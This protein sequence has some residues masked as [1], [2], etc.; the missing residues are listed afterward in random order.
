MDATPLPYDLGT[1]VVPKAYL[2]TRAD[3]PVHSWKFAKVCYVYS[4]SGPS[5]HL[6]CAVHYPSDD[7]PRWRRGW[8]ACWRWRIRR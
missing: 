1:L 5:L 4:Q 7:M 2:P 6:L 3:E 8:P